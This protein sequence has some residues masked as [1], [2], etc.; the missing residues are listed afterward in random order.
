[1]AHIIETICG[2]AARLKAEEKPPLGAG[3]PQELLPDIEVLE[4]WGSSIKDPGPDWCEFKAFDRSGTMIKTIR[5]SG[6]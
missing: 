3:F 4:V 6:Y 2:D 1:M 5:V